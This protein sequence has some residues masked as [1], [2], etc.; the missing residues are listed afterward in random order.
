MRRIAG[1]ARGFA[2]LAPS[3]DQRTC[4]YCGS[5]L[6]GRAFAGAQGGWR[7]LDRNS[8]EVQSATGFG[9]TGRDLLRRD[10]AGYSCVAIKILLCARQA[11]GVP[12]CHALAKLRRRRQESIAGLAWLFA[13]EW[14]GRGDVT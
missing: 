10:W 6:V 12:D 1:Q 9:C 4:G 14:L 13:L 3:C 11:L 8:D 2:G 5:V 7:V